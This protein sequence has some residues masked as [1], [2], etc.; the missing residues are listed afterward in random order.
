MVHKIPGSDPATFVYGVQD[1]VE[2]LV[3]GSDGDESQVL[4]Q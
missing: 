1:R 3:A 4:D 2:A